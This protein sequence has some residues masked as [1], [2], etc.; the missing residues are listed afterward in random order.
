M[1]APE[2]FT[3]KSNQHAPR[4]VHRFASTVVLALSVAGFAA[5]VQAGAGSASF[6]VSATVVESCDISA[7]ALGFG[8]FGLV[9]GST[10]DAASALSAKCTAG[11]A[12]SIGLSAGNG[13]GAT[14]SS[15]KL[16]H[17][18]DTT[19]TLAYVL[20]AGSAGGANWG[21]AGETGVASG[22]GSGMAQAIPVYGRITAGQ[23]SA[24]M[25]LYNDTIIATIDF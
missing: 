6:R 23:T 14:T 13:A 5:A 9:S 21:G 7:N 11:S 24:A 20:S 25:G 3:L 12:F 15:R 16:T 4:G 8:A 18:A 10:I 19:R 22:T 2:D 17:A 1:R